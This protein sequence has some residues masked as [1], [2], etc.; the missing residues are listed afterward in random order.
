MGDQCSTSH[1]HLLFEAALE[2]YKK[3][4]GTTLVGHP[5]CKKLI[6]CNSV[7]SITAVL[8][9]Q[10]HAFKKFRGDDGK[11]MKSLKCAVHVLHSL[12]TSGVLGEAIS[13][14]RMKAL[15]RC[16]WFLTFFILQPFP[17]ARAVFAGFGIL[18]GVSDHF[19][20]SHAG[21]LVTPV[22]SD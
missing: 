18:L 7:E 19:N 3:Q 4:T 10:A 8:Q 16:S 20:N 15:V 2:D 12:S 9:E 21:T 6:T 22:C 1:F 17:P 11:V 5:L 14:V 13:L